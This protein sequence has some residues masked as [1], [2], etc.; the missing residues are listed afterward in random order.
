MPDLFNVLARRWKLILSL[1]LIAALLALGTSFLSPEKY[2][3]TAT[4]LP[5]NV[6]VNER[7][8]IFN[9]NIQVLYSDFG[10]PDELDKLEGT[11]LLDTIFLAVA[12]DLS[13]D[14]HYDINA[15][16]ESLY[17][18]AFKL[19][20]N[21]KINRS[22]YGELK[23]KAWDK[24]NQM[25]AKMANS[26]LQKIQQLHQRLQNEN[27]ILIL[28]RLKEDYAAKQQL[29]KKLSDSSTRF[30]GADAE[31][32]NAKK[33]AMLQQ[34]QEYEKLIDQYHIT[35]NTN[36]Q[37]LLTVETAKASLWPDKP[38]MWPTVLIAAFAAFVI[39]FIIALFIESRNTRL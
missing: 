13:L 10:T 32:W 15:G 33:T 37:V 20:K 12:K 25:A 34:V 36:P 29:Y 38:K 17:G 6:M 22:A 18:A 16:N 7:S 23:I 28:Q 26:L 27:S 21:S 5:V 30:D 9:P 4:A 1:T 3:S 14:Q 24:D 35:I 11:A 31:L 19:K 39:A 2:L 8:R